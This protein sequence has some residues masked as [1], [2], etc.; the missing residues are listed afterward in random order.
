MDQTEHTRQNQPETSVACDPASSSLWN[1]SIS[2][3]I[4]GIGAE[5]TS[6]ELGTAN[7]VGS[8]T[9]RHICFLEWSG[10][11]FLRLT[12]CAMDSVQLEGLE[13]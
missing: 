11:F 7:M 10:A 8:K 1:V 5:H 12:F 9:L 4:Q 6:P 3:I 2:D 13:S